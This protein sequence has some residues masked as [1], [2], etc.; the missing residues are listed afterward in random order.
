[1]QPHDRQRI[2]ALVEHLIGI[3]VQHD[4]DIDYEP[5]P[6]EL[7]SDDECSACPIHQPGWNGL[8]I[9]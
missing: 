6:M 7:D 1:M 3:L 4:G 2:E 9:S 8:A 5:E